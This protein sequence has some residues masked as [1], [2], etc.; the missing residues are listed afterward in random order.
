MMRSFSHA[1]A[2]LFFILTLSCFSTACVTTSP[3]KVACPTD[4][5][6][7]A[8]NIAR[9][10]W[11][12]KASDW[13]REVFQI[14][15][16]MQQL[17][18]YPHWMEMADWFKGEVG[19]RYVEQITQHPWDHYNSKV[20]WSS[21]W[22]KNGPAVYERTWDLVRRGWDLKNKRDMLNKESGS[23]YAQDVIF[24]MCPG[25]PRSQQTRVLE[26]ASQLNKIVSN[27]MESKE[28]ATVDE[29]LH[30]TG[31]CPVGCAA[32]SMQR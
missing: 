24:A 25:L 19:R 30:M 16:E 27:M 17:Q 23:F 2:C 22:E 4:K 13:G 3:P 5:E 1:S 28:M 9:D 32:D 12:P 15:F 14:A 6:R 21:R 8:L 18:Q 29:F 20:Y 10:A 31:F 7:T 11:Y 26:N